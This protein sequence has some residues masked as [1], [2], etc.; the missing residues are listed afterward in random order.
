MSR[1]KELEPNCFYR[2]EYFGDPDIG[3]LLDGKYWRLCKNG[4]AISPNEV[5]VV[6]ST[7]VNPV[8]AD[9]VKIVTRPKREKLD[10]ETSYSAEPYK[11]QLEEI[12]IETRAAKEGE[13]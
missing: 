13:V 12:T 8:P 11:S 2:I 10:P 5:K 4:G 6:D 1:E 7:P 9:D 3:F